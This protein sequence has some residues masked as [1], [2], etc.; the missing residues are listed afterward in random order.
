MDAKLAE[1]PRAVV[2]GNNPPAKPTPFELAEKAVNDI[3]DETVL[4]ARWQSD[5]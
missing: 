3:Y 5:R 2:G 1:N 4:V